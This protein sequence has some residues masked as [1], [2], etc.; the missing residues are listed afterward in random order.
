M[1]KGSYVICS[2]SVSG[3]HNPD[4]SGYCNWCQKKAGTSMPRP[5]KFSPPQRETVQEYYDYHYNPDYGLPE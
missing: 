3:M 1:G 5:T 2:G 4:K